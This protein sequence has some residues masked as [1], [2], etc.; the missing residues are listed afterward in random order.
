[1]VDRGTKRHIGGSGGIDGSSQSRR[2]Q[3]RKK[4][5][6]EKKETETSE[7]LAEEDEFLQK[8]TRRVSD[9]K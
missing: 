4:T 6:G 2:I 8:K 3:R 5:I 7:E 1:M 9:P